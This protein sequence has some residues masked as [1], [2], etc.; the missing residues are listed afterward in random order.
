MK[1]RRIRKLIVLLIAVGLLFSQG[2]LLS[3]K[4]RAVQ[5]EAEPGRE[6]LHFN[7]GWKFVRQNIPE[8]IEVDYDMEELERWENVDL[9]HSVRLE[10]ENNSGGKNYQ[11]PAMYRKHFYLSDSYEGKKLY[12]EFEGVMGVTDVWVNGTH[13]Q[14]YMA[15][16]TGEN[17]QYGGYLPFILDITDAVHCDGEANVI[18]VLTDNSDN[19]NVP[20]G[21]PQGQLDFTY[22]GGIYRN[23]W[24]HSMNNVHI[25]DAIF[26]DVTAGGG[27]LVDYP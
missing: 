8:A 20:P 19:I 15:K 14:G 17:T 24:L 7:Q 2:I 23:V 4:E 16:K 22:F 21:K 18:T 10:A 6:K 3:A 9:P 12:I 5:I 11:G 13:L 25:T 1:K 26:E 27:I